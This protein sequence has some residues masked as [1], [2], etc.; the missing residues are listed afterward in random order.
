MS[1]LQV[2]WGPPSVSFSVLRE[3]VRAHLTGT[4]AR[5]AAVFG[6]YAR[7][8]ADFA[9]DLDLIIVEPT[10]DP[11]VE[12]GRRHLPLFR[13]GVGID[14]LVYTPEEYEQLRRGGNRLIE[15]IEREGIVIYERPAD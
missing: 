10:L 11:F 15:R 3:R 7:G 14:L 13:L 8:S 9:S 1:E 4:P 12:R 5:W 6:S 2:E